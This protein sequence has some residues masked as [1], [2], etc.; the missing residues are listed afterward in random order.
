MNEHFSLLEHLKGQVRKKDF[1]F[2]ILHKTVNSYKFI[3]STKNNTSDLQVFMTVNLTLEISL[4]EFLK[5]Y[6]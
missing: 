5:Y 2:L 1:F 6:L 4:S 3:G